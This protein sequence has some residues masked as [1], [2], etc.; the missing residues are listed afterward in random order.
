TIEEIH[1]D[2]SSLSYAGPFED[3]GSAIGEAID[4]TAT[5]ITKTVGKTLKDLID[6]TVDKFKDVK[7]S[8]WF[9]DTVSKLVG[10]G[11]IDGYSDGTFRPNNTITK[12]EFIKM[13]VGSLGYKEVEPKDSH[14]AINYV[15]KAE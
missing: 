7:V 15:N 13:T 3:I 5:S 8:D 11:G 14:W 6:Y 12:A 1:E 4:N 10:K 9:V 2:T